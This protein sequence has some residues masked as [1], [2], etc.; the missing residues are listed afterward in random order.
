MIGIAAALIKRPGNE[1][2]SPDRS[3]GSIPRQR[4]RKPRA[5]RAARHRSGLRYVPQLQ[6]NDAPGGNRTQPL[7]ED[8]RGSELDHAVNA[9]H[10][11]CN[12]SRRKPRG[13]GDNR[14]DGHPGK[15]DVLQQE[16]LPDY[17][18]TCRSLRCAVA[19]NRLGHSAAISRVEAHKGLPLLG[20][21]FGEALQGGHGLFADVMLKPFRIGVGRVGG[22]AD[23]EKELAH[24]TVASRDHCAMAWPRF[25]RKIAR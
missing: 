7:D 22:D 12:R 6:Q 23:R 10:D 11:E 20:Q 1:N 18:D 21:A 17:P 15:R 19:V 3:K 13:D 9:E 14:F 16:G 2:S 24:N 25:V 5:N 8:A 4:S